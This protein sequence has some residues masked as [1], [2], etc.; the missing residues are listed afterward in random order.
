METL[1]IQSRIGASVILLVLDLVWLKL[2]MGGKY[3]R[4]IADIQRSPMVVN[5]TYAILAYVVLVFGL[6]Y[7]VLRN[8]NPRDI[9]IQWCLH[10]A[11][12]FGMV[13]YGVYDFTCGAIFNQ[14][15]SK[16][17]V[18]D[19][20]WGGLLFAISAYSVKWWSRG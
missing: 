10:N 4:L 3:T 16:L 7:F 2:F 12:V 17:A 9:T 13:V 11:F 6:N 15:D 8:I 18:I 20:L 14:W 19:V 1:P 5:R